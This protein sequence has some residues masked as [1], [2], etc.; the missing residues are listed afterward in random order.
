MMPV[1]ADSGLGCVFRNTN[2]GT[3]ERQIIE[4]RFVQAFQKQEGSRRRVHMLH[5]KRS[6]SGPTQAAK[7]ARKFLE[8]L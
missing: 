3:G 2:K 4:A 8:D 1:N 6:Q 7:S 5:L